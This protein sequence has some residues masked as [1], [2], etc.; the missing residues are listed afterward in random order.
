MD[1]DKYIL[2]AGMT[3]LAA[4]YVMGFPI[5]EANAYP[6]GICSSYYI[7]PHDNLRMGHSPSDD[8]AYRFETGGGHWIFGADEKIINFIR[9]FCS[10]KKYDRVSSVY[11]HKN[12]LSVPY[13]IQNNLRFLP[14][15]IVEKT[16]EEITE[17]GK[18]IPNTMK[19]WLEIN[20]GTTLCEL[21]FN[22]FN[23]L[24]TAGLYDRIAPQDTYK[25][26]VDLELVKK[27]AKAK[28]ETVGYNSSF[29]Y[30]EK[31]L[32]ALVEKIAESCN[33]HYNKKIISID[34]KKKKLYFNNS[35]SVSY[36][37]VISTL[38][39]NETLHLCRLSISQKEDPYTSVL[40]LNIGAKRGDRCPHDHWLYNLDTISGFHRV[41]FY[42]N[43]DASF[44][45]VSSRSKGDKVSIY[46]ERA[47]EGGRMPSQ[48]EINLYIDSVIKELKDWDF[49]KETEV[50][51]INWINVAYTWSWPNSV[52]K[53]KAIGE[54]KKHAIYQVGRYGKWNFQGIADSIRDG[55][56]IGSGMK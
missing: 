56:T 16:L 33:V 49:I 4:G 37:K 36:D 54:L 53:K 30:P 40:V 27:G 34:T 18:E 47:F 20:F 48:T 52:W 13:P 5:F 31:G 1:K 6:G 15:D 14:R 3:G 9:Q 7:K 46:V 39:L 51:D 29:L 19:Q 17:H 25:S 38:P 55:L 26:P 41:G 42:S 43:V 8:D 24:Y 44:L 35:E 2:G 45:P 12:E 11:F 22:P 50:I 32:D 21:F 10:L 23:R 28:P